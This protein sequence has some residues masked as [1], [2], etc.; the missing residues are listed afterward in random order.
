MSSAER[1]SPSTE[2]ET[3]LNKEM[4]V[5]QGWS[6]AAETGLACTG[7]WVQS[8]EP[9][10]K[11]RKTIQMLPDYTS[12]RLS[13]LGKLS[14]LHHFF[15]GFAKAKPLG[16]DSTRGPAQMG[17]IVISGCHFLRLEQSQKAPSDPF[18]P[19]QCW[20]RVCWRGWKLSG[21]GDGAVREMLCEPQH[22]LTTHG[23]QTWEDP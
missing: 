13:S 1:A 15:Q 8:L 4:L 18:S 22:P 12:G 21:R 19:S 16:L 9:I 6:S 2:R 10:K 5:E 20:L 14:F 7:P 3:R 11:K 23:L 17:L